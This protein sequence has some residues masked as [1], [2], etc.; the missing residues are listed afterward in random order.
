M[1]R[2]KFDHEPDWIDTRP[3]LPY[4]NQE[5]WVLRCLLANEKPTEHP[6]FKADCPDWA[7]VLK[8]LW[9]KEWVMEPL[10]LTDSGRSVIERVNLL[11]P[12]GLPTPK[13]FKVHS[14]PMATGAKVVEDEG[15]FPRLSN[16]MRKV[17]GIDMEA[18]GLAALAEAHD[19]PVVIAKGVSDFGDTFKDDRYRHFAARASAEVIISFL[20]NTPHLYLPSDEG[21]PT[22][23]IESTT[24][25]SSSTAISTH[26]RGLINTL[27]EFYPDVAQVRALWE[28]A[29]GRVGDIENN[30][31]PR[32]LWQRVLRIS[33]Q[34]AVVSPIALLDEVHADYPDNG[35]IN[36]H[37]AILNKETE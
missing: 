35:V 12:K 20:R 21:K 10:N 19:I 5:L 27:A 17:L 8:R 6:D 23:M 2:I 13:S 16:S 26:P 25:R 37:L 18:S 7:E 30:P 31:R 9:K 29:G 15:I 1:Q 22:T 11:H 4:E 32:D 3:K 24:H 28:R 33:T 36:E 34:G 14:A